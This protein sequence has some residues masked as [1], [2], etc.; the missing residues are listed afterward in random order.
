MNNQSQQPNGMSVRASANVFYLLVCAHS[1][2]FTVFTRHSFGVEGLGTNGVAALG[3]MFAYACYTASPAMLQY[4]AIWFVAL[5]LQRLTTFVRTRRG[6]YEHSR[7]EGYPWLAFMLPF[8]RD[9][10]GAKF[11]EML[12]CLMAGTFFL[13]IDEALGRFVL[14]GAFSLLAQAV[15]ERQGET[16]RLQAMRDAEIEMRGLADRFNSRNP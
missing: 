6:W 16:N 8:V 11:F 14:F 12:F 2:C 7:Y 3:L 5:A 9:V 15:I 13:G 10:P 1:T 4:L